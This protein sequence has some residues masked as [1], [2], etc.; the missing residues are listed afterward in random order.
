MPRGAYVTPPKFTPEQIE[1]IKLD[2]SNGM[3]WKQLEEKYATTYTTLNKVV[4]GAGPYGDKKSSR[5]PVRKF[6]R[7]EALRIR[8][9][10]AE[11]SFT[12]D[13]LAG[14]HGCGIVHMRDLLG[15]T[16]PYAADPYPVLGLPGTPRLVKIDDQM[17]SVVRTLR[18]QKH[19][20][21]QIAA[22]TGLASSTVGKILRR[23][24]RY[25]DQQGQPDDRVVRAPRKDGLGYSAAQARG[26]VGR[27]PE[28]SIGKLF[29]KIGDMLIDSEVGTL[30]QLCQGR[31]VASPYVQS[32]LDFVIQR[33]ISFDSDLSCDK[34]VEL[35]SNIMDYLTGDIPSGTDKN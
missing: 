19:T 17:V 24:G 18:E 28:A 32:Q 4:L 14:M 9:S 27:D 10:F 6:S 11:G 33:K 15:C 34:A 23:K 2:R 20:I 22:L 21:V 12:I 1:Q 25:A 8:N 3:T 29:D 7:A 5:K 16:G 26:V 30:Q 31:R 13:A 35:R